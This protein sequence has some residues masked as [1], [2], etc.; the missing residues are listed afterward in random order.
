MPNRV[1]ALVQRMQSSSLCS[2]VR[3]LLADTDTSQLRE[4][5]H[6][7]LNSGQ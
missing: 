5:D 3:S 4:G 1:N 6:T 2:L 7:V